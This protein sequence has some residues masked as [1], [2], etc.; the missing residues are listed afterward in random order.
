MLADIC[1]M[2]GFYDAATSTICADFFNGR[3]YQMLNIYS[4]TFTWAKPV[5]GW[6]LYEGYDGKVKFFFGSPQEEGKRFTMMLDGLFDGRR[7]GQY[8]SFSNDMRKSYGEFVDGHQ[9]AVS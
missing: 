2:A 9:V 1:Q 7:L 5:D 4:N 3:D 6:I 8:I